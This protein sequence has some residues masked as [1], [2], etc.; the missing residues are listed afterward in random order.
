MAKN[1]IETAIRNIAAN[2]LNGKYNL[3]QYKEGGSKYEEKQKAVLHKQICERIVAFSEANK[4][5][6]LY[7]ILSVGVA[8]NACKMTEFQKGYKKFNEEKVIIVAKMG[9]AYNDYNGQGKKKMSDVTIRLITRYY[10][11]V[12]ENYDTF[13][14]DLN[15]SSNLGKLCGSRTIKYEKLCKNLNIPIKEHEDATI[16]T[17]AA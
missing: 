10:E 13:L 9:R 15:N 12:S 5:I 8:K 2:K 3:A 16:T 14:K 1:N 17:E 6:P 4:D 11:K 7:F